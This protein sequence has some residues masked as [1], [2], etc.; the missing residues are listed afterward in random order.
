M[1]ES[2]MALR[3]S[4]KEELG[5][6][7]L[8]KIIVVYISLGHRIYQLLNYKHMGSISIQFN[9]IVHLT[10]ESIRNYYTDF[11]KIIYTHID[12]LN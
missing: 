7:F 5:Y 2:D 3:I 10:T 4:D 6:T 8:I 12:N 1:A 11:D 9:L